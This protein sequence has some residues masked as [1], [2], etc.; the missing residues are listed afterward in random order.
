MEKRAD[1][2]VFIVSK[3]SKCDACG[4]DLGRKAWIT[5]AGEAGALCLSC[6]DL[7]HLVFLPSGDTALTRR[8]RKYANLSAVVL[9]WSKARKRYERQGILVEEAALEK[10]E[11]ECLEDEVA[12]AQ[13]R[14]R[15]AVRRRQLDRDYVGRFADAIRQ[16]F[17][18]CPAKTASAIAEHA[19]LKFS[20]R[21]GRSAAA[22]A[23]D[24]TAIHLAAVAHVRHEKTDYDALLMNGV[25]RADARERVRH[26]L[27]T[28]LK[29]WQ[30]DP[31][32]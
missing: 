8:S 18:G 25:E 19:C 2:R 14:E 32:S 30:I 12:R 7:D 17:P 20:G 29:K 26:R 4:M 11:A 15:A 28:V 21:V 16:M 22:K 3:A 24:E 13:R 9:K 10:A 6:A 5:L 23:F 1:I 27:D 31:D